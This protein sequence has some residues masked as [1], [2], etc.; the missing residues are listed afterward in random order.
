MK[1]APSLALAFATVERP[2][3]VQ[4]LI[5]SVRRYY[6]DLPIYVAD[7]S[8][9]IDAIA[10][11]YEAMQVTVVAMPYDIGVT[12]SRNRLVREITED[13]FILCDDDFIFGPE[14]SFSEALRILEA[15][16]EIGVVG[17]RLFDFD[18]EIEE[19]RNWELYLEYDPANKILLSIPIVRL[20]PQLRKIGGTHYYLCD[21][22]LNFSVFR[23][24]IFAAGVGWDERFKSNG[25]HEDFYLNMKLNTPFRASYLPTLIAYHHHPEAYVNYRFRLRERNEGWR[26]FFEKWGLEQ[27][28]EL[29]LGVRPLDDIDTI[30]PEADAAKRF[31]VNPSLSLRRTEVSPG[32]LMI[33]EFTD[34]S[35]VGAL[36]PSGARPN[37]P[38]TGHLLVRPG[39][40]PLAISPPRETPP[41]SAL[42]ASLETLLQR[43]QLEAFREGKTV[44]VANEPLYFR[45]DPVLRPE[46]DFFVWYFC[47]SKASR[48]AAAPSR[49]S[50]VARWWDSSGESLIW[51]SRR[52]FIDLTPSEF[53][54]P[55]LLEVPLIARGCRW[56]R[57]DLV[58]DGGPSANPVCSGLMSPPA[59]RRV[60]LLHGLTDALAL[61]RLH[62]DGGS[63]GEGGQLLE[64]IARSC[65]P[66][67]VKPRKS[68]G[69]SGLSVLDRGELAGFEVLYFVGWNSLGRALVSARLPPAHLQ[70]PSSIVLPE[71]E[72]S[73]PYGRI[74]AY[75]SQAGL[76]AL[77]W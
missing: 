66:Q 49:L 44:A 32:T 33:G 4:R 17:G 2:Q 3:V 26:L 62:N 70:A 41:V 74:L 72:W 21:A 71:S 45:Y 75:G 68:N 30:V 27:H 14:T 18:G 56:L 35:A 57:F 52:M 16:Q 47:D 31:F 5:L 34:V 6:P 42:P 51:R 9:H 8:R 46:S 43:Y 1:A 76:T 50:V 54:R 15:D 25:E 59:D 65:R 24:S 10:H 23:R 12:T 29:G 37:G 77:S 11:F 69:A 58:T 7:Q 61:C 22:V 73:S 64:D 36:S 63:P 53:W 13:Y 39:T 20:A 19:L 38:S 67:Q 40:P 48:D 60:D 28:I 55:L